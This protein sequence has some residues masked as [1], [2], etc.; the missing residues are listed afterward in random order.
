MVSDA[1]NMCNGNTS[2]L[3]SFKGQC[4][5]KGYV[6]WVYWPRFGCIQ[7]NG[8]ETSLRLSAISVRSRP[9]EFSNKRCWQRITK[10]SGLDILCFITCS[11]FYCSRRFSFTFPRVSLC[12]QLLLRFAYIHHDFNIH[13]SAT[14]MPS[15]LGVPREVRL[16]HYRTR[17]Q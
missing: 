8:V 15:L 4:I 2:L 10:V 17:P 11:L 14:S 7:E 12:F 13:S 9:M 16:D 1:R 3:A 5:P 6:A